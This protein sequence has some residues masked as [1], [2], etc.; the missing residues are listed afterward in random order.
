MNYD[1]THN[2][3]LEGFKRFSGNIGL[4][5]GFIDDVPVVVRDFSRILGVDIVL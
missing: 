5:K 4:I 3:R 1:R 2:I